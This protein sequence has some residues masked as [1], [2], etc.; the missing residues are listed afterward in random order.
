M[1]TLWTDPR[2]PWAA[3]LLG[4]AVVLGVLGFLGWRRELREA[5]EA[6]A[7]QLKTGMTVSGRAEIMTQPQPKS[8]AG[9]PERLKTRAG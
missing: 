3:T 6:E 4:I 7:A 5:A 9:I 2:L 8:F 1:A